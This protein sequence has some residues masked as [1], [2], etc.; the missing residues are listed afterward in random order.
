MRL[1][2]TQTTKAWYLKINDRRRRVV[3][4]RCYSPSKQLVF[5][6]EKAV[7]SGWIQPFLLGTIQIVHQTD[8]I[9]Q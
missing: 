9:L 8:T 5:K 2:R 7:S 3:F 6:V 1:Y 4:P